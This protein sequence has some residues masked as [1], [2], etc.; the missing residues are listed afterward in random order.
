MIGALLLSLMAAGAKPDAGVVLGEQLPLALLVKTPEELA[1]KTMTERQ[2]LLVTLLVNAKASWD[3]QDW[4]GAATKWEA[5]LRLP[6]IP[7][8]VES[9]A[10][11]FGKVARERAG[12]RAS[13]LPPLPSEPPAVAIMME[14][15]PQAKK[16]SVVTVVGSVQGGG[17]HGP[18]GAVVIFRKVNGTTPKP[19]AAR[20]R[21][22]VQKDKR[23]LPHVLAIPVGATVEFRNDDEFFHN[24]FSISKPNDFDLGLYKSGAMREQ[25]FTTPGPVQLL[26]NIHSSMSGWLFVS[27]SPWFTQADAQGKFAMKGVPPGQWE[28]EVWHEWASQS[29]KQVV[30]VTPLMSEVTLTVDGDRRAPAFVPDKSGKP[31]QPQLGY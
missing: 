5:V 22:V 31:R 1:Y 9:A 12:G 3:R 29:T 27:D 11:E 23:F 30:T 13:A 7:P 19:R 24:V 10:R 2:Y 18:G 8:D 20:V 17:S 25:V 28:V 6:S 26:C 16:P 15:E 14:P 21:A 4:E